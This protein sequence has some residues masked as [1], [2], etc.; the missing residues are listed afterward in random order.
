MLILGE[1]GEIEEIEDSVIDGWEDVWILWVK[2][3][4]GVFSRGYSATQS[5]RRK[6]LADFDFD[7][8]GNEITF[9]KFMAAIGEV[10]RGLNGPTHHLNSNGNGLIP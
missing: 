2:P 5:A 8:C 10:P 1:G 6:K 7:T 9:E 4:L 3:L